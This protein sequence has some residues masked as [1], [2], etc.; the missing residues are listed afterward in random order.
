MFQVDDLVIFGRKLTASEALNGGLV[1]RVL[2][3]EGF[4]SQLRA[5]VKDIADQPISVSAF[6]TL[7]SCSHCLRGDS[8]PANLC[9]CTITL[10]WSQMSHPRCVHICDV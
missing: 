5:I 2:W 3:P 9:R 6:S 10:I 1:S 4:V 7:R 8:T